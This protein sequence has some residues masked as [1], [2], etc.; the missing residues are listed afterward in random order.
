[1][2]KKHTTESV[3][4]N[5]ESLSK[6]EAFITKHNKKIV[7]GIIALVAIVGAILVFNAMG[8]KK[9]HESQEAFTLTENAALNAVDSLSYASALAGLEQYMNEYG[10]QSVAVAS[11]E[12]GVAAFQ[13]KD[14]NKA[15]EY[16][17]QYSSEDEIF[18]ARALACI[19][20]C[21]V[22]LG[23][24]NKAYE[25][26]AAAVA[27]ADNAFASDYAFKAAVVAENLGK[28]ENALAMYTTIK[29]KYPTTPRANGIDKY[30][31]R[32]EAMIAAK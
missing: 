22:E 7:Y 14:F 26:Y 15:I 5:I 23:N 25:N 17:S 10:D 21:Y 31:S 27:K 1:M 19:G 9:T 6:A 30:I 29:D 11:F 28:Y 18:N 8:E 2:A 13:V 3:D 12:A 20:D 24:L 32:A 16:F 4:T